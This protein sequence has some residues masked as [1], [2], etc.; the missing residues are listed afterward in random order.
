MEQSGEVARETLKWGDREAI[1]GDGSGC[2][3]QHLIA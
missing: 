3:V 1:H 2:V